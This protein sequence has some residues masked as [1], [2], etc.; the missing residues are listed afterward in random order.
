MGAE[1]TPGG[2]T[3]T[4]RDATTGQDSIA[5]REAITAIT[6]REVVTGPPRAAGTAHDTR[7]RPRSAAVTVPGH[8]AVV[9]IL[10]RRQM[11]TALTATVLLAALL[12]LL[13]LVFRLLPLAGGRPSA[14]LAVWLVLGVA[15]YPALL[16][17]GAWYVRRAERN[18]GDV[19][20]R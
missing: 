18:E 19:T 9:R 8:D 4:G 2:E 6:G 14:P 12:G 10:M 15:P 20:G 1:P 16:A 7:S 3:A 5:G 17:I 11:R 13:P